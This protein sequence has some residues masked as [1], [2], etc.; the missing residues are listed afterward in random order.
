M[1]RSPWEEEA[2]TD[3][4]TEQLGRSWKGPLRV[5][6]RDA[7]LCPL[8][9]LATRVHDFPKRQESKPSITVTMRN[10]TGQPWSVTA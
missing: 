3:R 7:A 5:H 2:W 9:G 1:K 10:V 8:L 6:L 4:W